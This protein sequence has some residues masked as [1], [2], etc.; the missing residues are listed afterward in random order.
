MAFDKLQAILGSDLGNDNGASAVESGILI[1][2]PQS[3]LIETNQGSRINFCS[4]NYLGLANHPEIINH[5][6]EG[7]HKYGYGTAGARAICGTQ[8]IHTKLERELSAFLKKEDSI[9]YPSGFDA[10]AG[11]FEALTD[12]SDTILSDELNHASIIDGIRLAQA[13]KKVYKHSDVHDLETKLCESADS[14]MQ[15]IVTDGVFSM[16][17]DFAHLDKICDL[18]DQYNALVIVDDAH[19]T[20]IVGENGRGTPEYT[21]TED[22]IDLITSSLGKALGGAMG[23]VVSGR[24]LI[25][26][27][28]RKTSRPYLFSTSLSPA[29][30]TGALKA[31]ELVRLQPSLRQ[32]LATNTTYMR[33][34]LT[35]IGLP[36]G[37]GSHPI[38][39]IMIYDEQLAHSFANYVNDHGIYV[40]AFTFPVVPKGQAR[41]R[42][43]ISSDH[44]QQ[45]LDKAID[46]FHQA[47]HTIGMMPLH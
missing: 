22:R 26:E 31:I 3:S 42:I 1:S 14:R 36:I 7:L 8:E 24:A 45:Q 15:I 17:G 25:I 5:V 4:N 30:V 37:P 46:T 27:H 13:H 16:Q 41:I 43:Q 44:T 19:G 29:M 47:A 34:N 40:K 32:T 6:I 39:P 10:N 2:S 20:G 21:N 23:G 12:T 11:L 38:I 9:L 28:L 33:K 18:A 35:E